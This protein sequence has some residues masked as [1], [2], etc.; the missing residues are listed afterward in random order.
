MT[1]T[2]VAVV[3]GAASGIGMATCRR[4]LSEGWSV[5]AADINEPALADLMRGLPAEWVPRV[6]KAVC[7]VSDE[8]SVLSAVELA[9]SEFNALNL[10]VNNAGIG[11]AFGPIT[12]LEAED[13]DFTFK[14]LTAGVFYGVKHAAA[15][16]IGAATGGSIVNIAS[17]A[18]QV[19]GIG[20]HAYSAAKAAVI[21]LTRTTAMEL[22]SERIRVNAVCP[23]AVGT[24]LLH[25]GDPEAYAERLRNVQPW[26]DACTPEDLAGVVAFLASRDSELITGA[27]L[28][29]DGGLLAAG[30]GPSFMQVLEMDAGA[31]GLVGINHGSTGQ[32]AIIRR[33]EH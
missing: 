32:P 8:S 7:D 6:R 11:G 31:A 12:S 29:V 14:V 24:P 26:P 3:T 10:M 1:E 16:M 18:G 9:V 4:L 13:W 19:G 17:T 20:P 2:R 5:V 23:G 30:P 21:S 15:A 27:A 25:R 28:A 33:R 22:A